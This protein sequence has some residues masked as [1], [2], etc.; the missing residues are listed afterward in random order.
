MPKFDLG[1]SMVAC[2]I[3]CEVPTIVVS[4][5]RKTPTGGMKVA[6]IILMMSLLVKAMCYGVLLLVAKLAT[7]RLLQPGQSGKAGADSV[8]K[9]SQILE[10]G[11]NKWQRSKVQGELA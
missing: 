9:R 6:M 11:R 4:R 3:D 5:S 8:R 7:R 2:E 1:F 10:S